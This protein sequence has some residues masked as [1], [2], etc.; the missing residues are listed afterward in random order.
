MDQTE[1]GGLPTGT[2]FTGVAEERALDFAQ[3]LRDVTEGLSLPRKILVTGMM[4]GNYLIGFDDWQEFATLI[5]QA[6]SEQEAWDI[7]EEFIKKHAA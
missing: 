6:K 3:T 7:T 5:R 2:P 4:F 1:K